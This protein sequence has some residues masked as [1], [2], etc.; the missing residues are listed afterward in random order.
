MNNFCSF[1]SFGYFPTPIRGVDIPKPDGKTRA[2]GIPTVADRVAQRAVRQ[3]P[4][5][6]HALSEKKLAFSCIVM[7]SN[8]FL[9]G[10][11]FRL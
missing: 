5:P 9:S 2:L 11:T 4:E 6:I 10:V 7:Y 1:S 8:K 3:Y